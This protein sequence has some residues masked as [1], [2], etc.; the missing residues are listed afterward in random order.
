MPGQ[1]IDGQFRRPPPG[2][3]SCHVSG[4]FQGGIVVLHGGRGGFSLNSPLNSIIGLCFQIWCLCIATPF[5][6]SITFIIVGCLPGARARS[7][8]AH[9]DVRRPCWQGEATEDGVPWIQ[10]Q[11]PQVREL[12]FP[13]NDFFSGI[14]FFHFSNGGLI[15]GIHPGF[16]RYHTAVILEG[17]QEGPQL[18]MRYGCMRIFLHL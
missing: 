6:I 9:V 13:E 2:Q 7:Q 1:F 17:F 12:F 15:K 3:H 10:D 14:F 18:S 4:Q 16:P 5:H 8:R 11:G